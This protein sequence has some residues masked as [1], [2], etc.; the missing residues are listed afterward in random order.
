MIRLKKPIE[1][2]LEELRAKGVVPVG[3]IAYSVEEDAF[4]LYLCEDVGP[5]ETAALLRKI[6]L[7]VDFS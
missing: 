5:G 1:A 7:S 3:V 4:R 6:G 2:S